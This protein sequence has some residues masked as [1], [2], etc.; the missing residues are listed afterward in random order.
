MKEPVSRPQFSSQQY[1]AIERT[2]DHKSEYISGHIVAMAGGSRRHSLITM[3]I[4]GE[5]R[6]LLKSSSCRVYNSDLKVRIEAFDSY[7]YPDLTITCGEEQFLDSQN[8]V[9]LNPILIVEVLAPSTEHHDRSV[10][11]WQ[12]Q[13]IPSLVEYVL[14]WQDYPVIEVFTRRHPR[15][16]YAKYEG[17]SGMVVLDSIGCRLP[18][19]DV[20]SKVDWNKDSD[21]IVP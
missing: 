18:L 11:F 14:V 8:D 19:S 9:L 1:L 5:L 7:V 15:W 4:G 6:A 2:A 12:Y 13:Q 16:E 3:N 10:K 20:F 17:I 21:Q